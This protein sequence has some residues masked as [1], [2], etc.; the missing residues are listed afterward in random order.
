MI[1]NLETRYL[2]LSLA[3]PLV[4]GASPLTARLSTLVLFEQAGA[5]AAVMPSLF[6]EQIEYEEGEFRRAR[7]LVNDDAGENPGYGLDEYNCGPNSYLRQLETAKRAVSIPI[8][9]SVNARRAGPWTRFVR[10]FEESGADALELNIYSIPTS[11]TVSGQQVEDRCVELVAAVR[12]ETR[13]PL[14]IK[15]LDC[16]SALPHLA[17]RLVQAGAD[18]LV[19]FNR[20][21]APDMDL[22]S[23][24]LKPTLTLGVVEE[25]RSRLRWLA[26]LRS[27]LSISL[28]GTGGTETTEDALKLIV[29]GADV[30]MLASA[31]IRHGPLHLTMML[32]QLS[33]WLAARHLESVCAVRG[34]G[35]R[36]PGTDAETLERDVYLKTIIKPTELLREPR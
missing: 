23:F 13:L 9:A 7:R 32:E 5:S 33:R 24:E 17:A 3:N 11:P 18:G 10:L 36:N 26:I 28:A 16:Y 21:L 34:F 8:I 31:L 22:E 2:G 27:Q 6:Q 35:G 14:A 25:L 29:A 4:V 1:P 12:A 30:V 19:L 15:L 20:S